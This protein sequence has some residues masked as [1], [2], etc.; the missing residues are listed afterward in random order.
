MT[1][2]NPVVE[3]PS[4]VSLPHKS[5]PAW[6]PLIREALAKRGLLDS[7][8]QEG[9]SSSLSRSPPSLSVSSSSSLSSLSAFSSSFTPLP[10][11][12]LTQVGVTSPG[13]TAAVHSGVGVAAP[14]IPCESE[15]T[16]VPSTTGQSFSPSTSTLFSVPLCGPLRQ[17]ST[18]EQQ[19]KDGKTL[20]RTKK[21]QNAEEVAGRR[22]YNLIPGTDAKGI[23]SNLFIHPL[24]PTSTGGTR[25]GCSPISSSNGCR[26]LCCSPC[27]DASL[28]AGSRDTSLGGRIATTG[29][30]SSPSTC[31]SNFCRRCLSPSV[32]LCRDYEETQG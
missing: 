25:L 9:L 6:S 26:N 24:Y 22:G 13:K 15:G 3:P 1:V 21:K 20:D 12:R 7:G 11:P 29:S 16:Q 2:D 31:L 23:P 32:C 10:I 19:N 17:F 5:G 4:L 27:T 28:V 30:T 8:F 14:V 18:P